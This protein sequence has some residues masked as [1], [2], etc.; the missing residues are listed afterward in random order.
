MGGQ[1]PNE[2]EARKSELLQKNLVFEVEKNVNLQLDIEA[3]AARESKLQTEIETLKSYKV[4]AEG[5]AARESKLRSQFDTLRSQNAKTETERRMLET[6][7][8]QLKDKSQTLQKAVEKG[9]TDRAKADN[10]L[11]QQINSTAQHPSAT[12]PVQPKAANHT[13][14]PSF[15]ASSKAKYPSTR[16]ATTPAFSLGTS[17]SAPGTATSSFPLASTTRT[18][19]AGSGLHGSHVPSADG[20]T[21]SIYVKRAAKPYAFDS[22]SLSPDQRFHVQEHGTMKGTG[23]ASA[24][25]LHLGGHGESKKRAADTE[26]PAE[27]KKKTKDSKYQK[28]VVEDGDEKEMMFEGE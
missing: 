4:K 16:S 10:I 17:T 2:R 13:P 6:K 28:P 19:S 8:D 15:G 1:T 9:I 22:S 18:A 7:C 20:I 21:Q 14:I 27:K 12:A 26:L 25:R 5:A 24:S 11:Y 3:A 23:S